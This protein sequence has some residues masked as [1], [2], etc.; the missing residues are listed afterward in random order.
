MEHQGVYAPPPQ[1]TRN[2]IQNPALAE[3]SA[4][5]KLAQ[6]YG[7]PPQLARPA[8]GLVLPG[9]ATNPQ[10]RPKRKQSGI[11]LHDG[12]ALVD[13][14]ANKILL[15]RISDAERES[16]RATDKLVKALVK[17]V[18]SSKSSKA[19][20]RRRAQDPYEEALDPFNHYPHAAPV[21]TV[22]DVSNTPSPR[23]VPMGQVDGEYGD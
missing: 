13:R 12:G 19:K 6:K 7:N 8:A 16:D 21:S 22:L 11:P 23:P 20:G 9:L 2:L 14:R 1:P 17:L 15:R 4:R 3:A 5:Q 18:N 10:Q